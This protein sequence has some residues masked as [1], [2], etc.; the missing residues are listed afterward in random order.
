MEGGP[1]FGL[2]SGR[3]KGSFLGKRSRL[4]VALPSWKDYNRRRKALK[5]EEL[6][7]SPHL[8]GAYVFFP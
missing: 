1:V 2:L 8:P 3:K 7:R 4:S 6:C 5:K